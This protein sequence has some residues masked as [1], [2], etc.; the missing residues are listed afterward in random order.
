MFQLGKVLTN[1]GVRN[2]SN[3]RTNPLFLSLMLI[4]YQYSFSQI[5]QSTDVYNNLYDQVIEIENTPLFNGLG[6]V[7]KYKVI[8]EYNKFFKSSEFL[9]ATIVYKGQYYPNIEMKYDLYEDVVLLTHKKGMRIVL[10]QPIKARIDSFVIDGHNFRNINDTAAETLGMTGFY[11]V[12]FDAPGFQLLEKHHK[13]RFERKGK[14]T[15]YSEFK[16]R[17][18]M[19]LFYNGSYHEIK[20]R[21][22]LTKLFP[23]YKSEIQDFSY[24]RFPKENR[25][26]YLKI[27][28]QKIN[29]LISNTKIQ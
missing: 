17:N 7:E 12:L 6:Y 10:L 9:P 18:K 13:R 2:L 19:I 4:L 15:V 25:S 1:R 24:S 16:Q 27:V 3:L 14:N 20:T 22:S 5:E 11:E 28:C 21:I 8:N 26:E 23:E 29:E